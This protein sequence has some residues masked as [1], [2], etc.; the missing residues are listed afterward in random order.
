MLKWKTQ[1][2]TLIEVLTTIA[3]VSILAA[4]IA[5]GVWQA[6]Q[7]VRQTNCASNLR[8][9]S[10]ALQMYVADCDGI[11]P[12]DSDAVMD[13]QGNSYKPHI[14]L[15]F[16]K[17]YLGNDYF[18]CPSRSLP[19]VFGK[20]EWHRILT[21]YACNS[22][23]SRIVSQGQN[24]ALVGRP[25]TALRFPSLTVTAFDARTGI[26]SISRA[27]TAENWRHYGAYDFDNRELIKA[28]PEGATRHGGGANYAFA[29][30]HVRWYRPTQLSVTRR[31]DGVRPGFG[32]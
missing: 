12:P 26:V 27:D 11:Y 32:L 2:F 5:S 25:D 29:D 15:D 9:I 6:R 10:V 3:V 21:G 23:L 19:G 30:G 18:Y 1:G 31:S 28:Q 20:N 17:P 14:W 13:A 24:Y 16:L 7:K 8:Q 22:R 4:I